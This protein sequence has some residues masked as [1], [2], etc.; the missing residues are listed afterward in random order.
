MHIIISF[1]GQEIAQNCGFEDGTDFL[2]LRR[3]HKL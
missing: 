1:E 3:L 2:F